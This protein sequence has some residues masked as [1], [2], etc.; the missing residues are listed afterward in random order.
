MTRPGADIERHIV[1]DNKDKKIGTINTE[2]TH[3]QSRRHRRGRTPSS[4]PSA[5]SLPLQDAAAAAAA[6]PNWYTSTSRPTA[7]PQSYG[8][9]AIDPFQ[10]YPPEYQSTQSAY[11]AYY[12]MQYATTCA[13][14][15]PS[16]N[17]LGYYPWPAQPHLPQQY[18][19]PTYPSSVQRSSPVQ[20]NRSTEKEL[21]KQEH[22][23]K[24]ASVEEATMNATYAHLPL[25]AS[26]EREEYAALLNGM[27]NV[28]YGAVIGTGAS[29]SFEMPSAGA[30]FSVKMKS[31]QKVAHNEAFESP[32]QRPPKRPEAA[33]VSSQD[34]SP[35]RSHRRDS[36]ETS[37]S[38]KVHTRARSLTTY[39]SSP[40]KSRG[41]PRTLSSSSLNAAAP[42]PKHH[43]RRRSSNSVFSSVESIMTD[44]S[45]MT[46]V[47]DI[48]RSS[49]FAGYDEVTGQ[50]LFNLPISSVHISMEDRK[51][52]IM[53]GEFY[54]MRESDETFE[55]YNQL[56]GGV[57]FGPGEDFFHGQIN[58]FQCSCTCVHCNAC[59]S[60]QP[61]ALPPTSYIITVPNDLYRRVVDEISSSSSLPCGLFFC[62]HHDDVAK[63]SLIIPLC[64]LA[65]LFGSMG[66]VAYIYRG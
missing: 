45:M 18:G 44:A 27:Q 35:R 6:V 51:Q 2:D 43:H 48:G 17:H 49:M 29:R 55:N 34:V 30:A 3:H 22:P 58:H 26:S 38:A 33:S 13:A 25:D 12:A 41:L 14:A 23:L 11:H 56:P 8:S 1:K 31:R 52:G 61:Y 63:P 7:H 10:R 59:E 66:F 21:D 4:L 36:S 50:A 20:Y 5:V 53:P 32:A 19:Y 60:K 24:K 47:T 9:P 39:E 16:G 64:I 37:R 42:S 28:S 62:G 54:Q 15:A 57:H 65:C 40:L 46:L